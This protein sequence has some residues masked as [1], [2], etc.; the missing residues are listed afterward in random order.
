MT[1]FASHKK[2]IIVD[3]RDH[4]LNNWGIFTNPAS[5]IIT[6]NTEREA[7]HHLKFLRGKYNKTPEFKTARTQEVTI[8]WEKRYDDE[9]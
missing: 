3:A 4:P 8:T 1:T 7:E 2:Y 9:K 5:S 6:F